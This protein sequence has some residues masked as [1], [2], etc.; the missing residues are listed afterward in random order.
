MDAR[1]QGLKAGDP[2]AFDA[3]W[4][5]LRAPLYG[6]LVRHT[7]SA[8]VGEE[9]LQE[10]FA[11]LARHAPRLRD[12]THLRGWL[13]AVARNLAVSWRRW[14]WLDLRRRDAFVAPTPAPSPPDAAEGR[15]AARRLEAAIAA[16]SLADREIVLLVGVEGMSPSAAAEVLGI[17]PEAARQRWA[18]AKARLGET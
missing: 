14:W 17:T 5:E 11:R 10:T 15:E 8:E 9:L 18:R 16:L 6:F 13:F 2:A 12:D 3:V 4:A 7:G 1:V